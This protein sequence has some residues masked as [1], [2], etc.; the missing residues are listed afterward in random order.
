MRTI[1]LEKY[2]QVCAKVLEYIEKHSKYTLQEI[3]EINSKPNVRKVD[4]N[5]KPEFV[6]K[7]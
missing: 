7:P 1:I 2:D 3:E 4:V 6:I 5:S